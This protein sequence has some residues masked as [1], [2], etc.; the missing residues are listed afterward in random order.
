MKPFGSIPNW[1]LPHNNMKKCYEDAS[2]K[3]LIVVIVFHL[4]CRR[5]TSRN[6]APVVSNSSCL[7]ILSCTPPE[8]CQS[9]L[10]CLPI[11]CLVFL[12]LL[13]H[14]DDL[15]KMYVQ[16]F[17]ALIMCPE[18]RSFRFLSGYQ[19]SVCTDL[20]HHGFVGSVIHPSD[21]QHTS[22]ACQCHLLWRSMIHCHP[23][24]LAI[25]QYVIRYRR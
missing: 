3:F 7:L 14:P 8:S 16:R 5:L 12:C 15:Q 1:K 23:M 11:V 17:C 25:L 24:Q 22:V 18:Y 21:S 19:F 9:S 10:L 4:H 13:H 2:H 20:V 6:D